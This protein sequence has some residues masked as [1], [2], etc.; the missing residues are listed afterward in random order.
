[1]GK[2]LAALRQSTPPPA[3]VVVAD[4][5]AVPESLEPAGGEEVPYI[6]IGPKRQIE[7]SPSVLAA[8]LPA[9]RHSLAHPAK[10]PSAT[11]ARPHGVQFRQMP[12]PASPHLAPE[13]VA[14][15]AA[16]QPAGRQYADLLAALVEAAHKRASAAQALLFT[17]VRPEVGA[18]TVL[19]NVAIT[20][21]HAGSKVVVVDANLRRPGVARKLGLADAPGLMEVLAGECP[22][23]EPLRETVVEN[24]AALTAGAPTA[25]L[26][27]VAALP[28]LLEQLR[29]A[30]DLVLIDGPRWDGRCGCRAL[31]GMCDAAFLVVPAGE[32]DTPPASELMRGLPGQGV[33]LA[34][35]VLTSS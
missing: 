28:L 4:P 11:L 14:Y 1:M 31:A 10:P 3:A 17:A 22:P 16:Q 5:A 25:V 23:G 27:D 29:E 24:L 21:A 12:Q 30:F 2:I 33:A 20:A 6:E 15:H 35:C 34:G 8:P 13:L 18:T 9:G 19:L 32:A 7:A 26:A